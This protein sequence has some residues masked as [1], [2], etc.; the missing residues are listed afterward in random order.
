MHYKCYILSSFTLGSQLYFLQCYHQLSFKLFLILHTYICHN[1]RLHIIMLPCRN[2]NI[3]SLPLCCHSSRQHI[4]MSQ[5]ILCVILTYLRHTVWRIQS[6]QIWH[7]HMLWLFDSFGDATDQS[8]QIDAAV[9]K[10]TVYVCAHTLRTDPD[11]S[12]LLPARGPWHSERSRVPKQP[13]FHIPQLVRIRSRRWGWI[14][15]D[16][17]IRFG[18][19]IYPEA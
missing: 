18:A 9:M 14:Q 16:E 11:I 6:Y 3:M 15:K 5:L 17:G 12:W 2:S 4:T 10:S 8:D 13:R 19:R 1:D 7:C